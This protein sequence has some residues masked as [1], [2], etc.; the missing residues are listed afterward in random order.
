MCIP[1]YLRNCYHVLNC[2]VVIVVVFV[3][4]GVVVNQ[5]KVSV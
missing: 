2:T 3:V 5:S 1:E 4:V